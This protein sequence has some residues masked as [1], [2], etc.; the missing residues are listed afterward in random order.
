[1]FGA[2][3]AGPQRWKDAT[4]QLMLYRRYLRTLWRRPLRKR[5]ANFGTVPALWPCG[6]H[7]RCHSLLNY[8]RISFMIRIVVFFFFFGLFNTLLC[9]RIWKYHHLLRLPYLGFY[10]IASLVFFVIAFSAG[11]MP[12][13]APP[14]TLSTVQCYGNLLELPMSRN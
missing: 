3:R 8:V 14:T 5:G 10:A 7:R 2:G 4:P 9:M 12:R 6:G 13:E 1:M 11:L